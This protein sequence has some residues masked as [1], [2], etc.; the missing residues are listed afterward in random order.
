MDQASSK[1]R[2]SGAFFADSRQKPGQE[3]QI[4]VVGNIFVMTSELSAPDGDGSKTE[5]T[6]KGAPVSGL[7]RHSLMKKFSLTL[8][9][10]G[11]EFRYQIATSCR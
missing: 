11:S 9:D 2:L 5:E 3:K 1:R 6:T 10:Q 4:Q 7:T 8:P